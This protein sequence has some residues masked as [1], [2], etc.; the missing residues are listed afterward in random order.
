M[1]SGVKCNDLC[2]GRY[3]RLKKDKKTTFAVF[4]LNKKMDEIIIDEEVDDAL[5]A[6]ASYKELTDL[7]ADKSRPVFGQPRYIFYDVNYDLPAGGG[8]RNK[9]FFIF[10]C[11]DESAK[12]AEKMV[13]A[14]SKT[15]VKK[16][17]SSAEEQQANDLYE[18]ASAAD[19]YITTSIAKGR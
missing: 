8:H 16:L 9:P 12:M 7:L 5:D 6:M 17:D 13:Y 1:T 2:Q 4:R 14:S 3:D 15:V 10:W 11:S 18:L 19:E